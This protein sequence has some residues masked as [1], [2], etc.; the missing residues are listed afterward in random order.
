MHTTATK[1]V[2]RAPTAQPRLRSRQLSFNSGD[3]FVIALGLSD[4]IS[5]H[6]IGDLPVTEFLGAVALPFLIAADKKVF[7]RPDTR[8][9]LLLAGL[10]IV[11][12]IISDMVNESPMQSRLK[13][14][15]RVLFFTLD[16]S[17]FSALIGRNTKRIV[18]LALSL[19]TAQM[20]RLP[21]FGL[22]LD[23][24]SWKFGE[25]A[26]VSVV[27]ML[28]GS[29]LCYKRRYVLFL[30]CTVPLML[31]NFHEGYRSQIAVDLVAIG[32]TLPIFLGPPRIGGGNVNNKYRIVPLLL[33][34]FGCV[35]MS[36]K[37]ISLGLQYGYFDD[38][39]QQKF[40]AQSGGE[41]GVLI[42]ARPEI[43]VALRAI[44]DAPIFG[45]GSYAVD[46]K[47][48]FLLQDFQYKYGYSGSDD[49][50]DIA[51]PGIP[52][53]SHL[54]MSWVE[55]GVLASFL[56]FYILYLIVRAI[57]IISA[58]RP[59]LAPFYAF[60]FITYGWD[61]LFS[62]FGYDRRVFEG[63]FLVLLLNVLSE[64]AT[65]SAKAFGKRVVVLRRQVV[66]AR[67]NPLRPV[68]LPRP[69][70]SVQ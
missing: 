9:I 7:T 22:G 47:Y 4:A 52:T 28:F 67:R 59:P 41:L 58:E 21:S 23:S 39:L 60:V 64:P 63:F 30:A 38:I 50:A 48:Q 33:I 42:G 54:T 18:L 15:A 8:R 31:V 55:G 62:P 44:A 53:H 12:Q 10:W 56:F 37:A 5:V 17:V 2:L 1:S 19:A 35:W 32:V 16:F 29:Y 27:L 45:H 68:S 13:G 24:T 65:E 51:D 14:L 36:Q 6:L 40:E 46:P 11:S 3:F 61:I 26:A 34:S 20:T 49:P 70:P 57:V 25:S 66:Q 69:R 43:P